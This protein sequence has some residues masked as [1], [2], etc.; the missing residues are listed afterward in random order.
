MRL[1]TLLE[2]P[3]RVHTL[4]K[5]HI[6]PRGA[7]SDPA[8]IFDKNFTDRSA[9]KKYETFTVVKGEVDWHD[10]SDPA[11]EELMSYQN[12]LSLLVVRN[13]DEAKNYYGVSVIFTLKDDACELTTEEPELL[14]HSGDYSSQKQIDTY[15]KQIIKAAVHALK[16]EKIKGLEKSMDIHSFHDNPEELEVATSHPGFPGSEKLKA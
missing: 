2:A 7:P 6:K 11:N 5:P 3:G 14:A 15:S 16:H 13:V 9:L 8:R 12:T 1:N 10:W 4:S